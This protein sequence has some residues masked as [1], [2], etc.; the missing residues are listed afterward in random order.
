MALRLPIG[1]N[2]RHETGDGQEIAVHLHC[3]T[4]LLLHGFH[5]FRV[6]IQR[7]AICHRKS[8]LCTSTACL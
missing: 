2:I 8:P 6:D 1:G 4:C 3:C 7:L 5:G